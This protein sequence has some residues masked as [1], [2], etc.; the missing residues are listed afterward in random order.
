ME[1]KN[2]TR[3]GNNPVIVKS[4]IDQY[5]YFIFRPNGQEVKVTV[6][7]GTFAATHHRLNA[8]EVEYFETTFN[9]KYRKDGSK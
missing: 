9:S 8:S 5:V 6:R 1:N 2:I 4:L 7:G 3:E